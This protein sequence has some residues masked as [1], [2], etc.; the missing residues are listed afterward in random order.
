MKDALS[1]GFSAREA[2]AECR[3]REFLDACRAGDLAPRQT[4]QLGCA[5]QE[6]SLHLAQLAQQIAVL[7]DQLQ[8]DTL[9]VHAYEGGHPDHDATAFA[10]HAAAQ[11]C[12]SRASQLVEFTSYHDRGGHFESGV[13][14]PYED[15]AEVTIRLDAE[16]IARKERMLACYRTQQDVLRQFGIRDERFRMAPAYDFTR[17]AHA[18]PAYYDRFPWGMTTS[19]WLELARA[20]RCQLGVC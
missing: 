10:V 16:D 18:G 19:R 17:P 9:L 15:A 11:M 12:S 20:A 3:R 5:D 7:I 4:I 8:V 14:L 2:Y 13:F 1:R 6:A